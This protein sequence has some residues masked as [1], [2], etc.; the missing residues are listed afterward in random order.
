MNRCDRLNTSL[1]QQNRLFS[2]VEKLNSYTIQLPEARQPVDRIGLLVF[3]VGRGKLYRTFVCCTHES[4]WTDRLRCKSSRARTTTRSAKT[5][6]PPLSHVHQP[7]ALP[8]LPPPP[9]PGAGRQYRTN[10]T[11]GSSSR[12]D[13]RSLQTKRGRQSTHART[14]VKGATRVLL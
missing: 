12:K 2:H 4:L 9:P 10:S 13:L 8:P 6:K 3:H 11:T 1:N 14:H 7:F 5:P